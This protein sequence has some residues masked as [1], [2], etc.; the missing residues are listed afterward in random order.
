MVF[1]IFWSETMVFCILMLS[2]HINDN[3]SNGW[4][5]IMMI[6][7]YQFFILSSNFFNHHYSL[8]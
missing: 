3:W 6:V 4:R 2:V 8:H 5:E 1:E 7:Y